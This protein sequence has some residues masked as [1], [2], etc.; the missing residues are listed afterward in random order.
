MATKTRKTKIITGGRTGKYTNEHLA[1]TAK[2]FNS[3]SQFKKEAPYEYKLAWERGLLDKCCSHMPNLH[4]SW[5]IEKL[6]EI[7]KQYPTRDEFKKG[8][9]QAYDA[10]HRKEVIDECC[11]HMAHVYT[12][13]THEQLL[14][15]A[16]KHQ[17]SS[18]FRIANSP[19]WQAA[20]ERGFENYNAHMTPKYKSWT[21]ELLIQEALK[22]ATRTEFA[23]GSNSAYQIASDSDMGIDQFCGHML[24]ILTYRSDTEL[25]E[26]ASHFRYRS[27]FSAMRPNEYKVAAT[28]RL[29]DDICSHMD[30]A[31][32]SSDKDVIY[33]WSMIY[34]GTLTFKVGMTSARRGISRIQECAANHGVKATV[35]RY[36]VVT[37]ADIL[38]KQILQHGKPAGLSG[39]GWTEMRIFTLEE[40]DVVLQ[41]IDS[42]YIS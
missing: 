10:A 16:Q 31:P 1:E 2:K 42:A 18:E 7:A 41:I 21:F 12:Q 4:N 15:E 8:N 32:G 35:I 40:L 22:Y 30:I 29:L 13:W 36:A 19:A 25:R 23:H 38:G 24:S 17:S 6:I 39:Q 34:E 28:R 20:H 33:L 5:T 26:V 11:A 9:P 37:R 14:A 3:R 27:E